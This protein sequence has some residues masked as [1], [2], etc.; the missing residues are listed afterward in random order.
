MKLS[1]FFLRW[2]RVISQLY[3][4]Y[5]TGILLKRKWQEG[6]MSNTDRN[7]S[8]AT[9]TDDPVHLEDVRLRVVLQKWKLHSC[10]CMVARI[11]IGWPS[12]W[13][14]SACPTN[15]TRKVADQLDYGV[16]VNEKV[17]A[18][19]VWFCDSSS[20]SLRMVSDRDE[21]VQLSY[22]WEWISSVIAPQYF[23]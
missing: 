23:C 7:S 4:T 14:M 16:L 18:C 1:Y 3:P 20:H 6:K 19:S 5:F 2:S 13:P 22:W 21:R 10:Q 12:I 11:C 9:L 15:D 8:A 17:I